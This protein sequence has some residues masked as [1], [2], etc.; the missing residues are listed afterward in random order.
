ML[1]WMSFIPLCG[2]LADGVKVLCVTAD[3]A[4]PNRKFFKMHQTPDLSVPHKAKN[5]YAKDERWVFFISDP[6]HLIKTAC[7]GTRHMEVREVKYK[8]V[9]IPPRTLSRT[10]SAVSVEHNHRHI[11][12]HLAH[13]Y[14]NWC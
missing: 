14:F 9:N 3:G 11:A 1:P 10:S 7:N 2:K 8:T 6:P 12:S 4:S 13:H 5:P